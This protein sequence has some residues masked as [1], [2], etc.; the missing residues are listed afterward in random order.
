MM[1]ETEAGRRWLVAGF[2]AL[3]HRNFRL[4][5]VG[6][7]LSLVGTWMQS[8]ALGWLVFQ[9]SGSPFA[10]GA[11]AACGYLPI[12]CLAPAAGAVA[13]RVPKRQL[14]LVT[15]TLAMLLALVLAVLVA[16]DRVTTSLVAVFAACL[17]TVSAFDIPTRQAFIVEMVGASDLPNAIALNSSIFNGARL[18]GPAVAGILVGEVGLAPCFFINAATYLAVLWALA[19]MQLPRAARPAAADAPRPRLGEGLRYVWQHPGLR[20]L[21]L[22]MGVVGS[23]GLQYTVLM[24]AFARVV[25]VTD[26]RGFG[27]LVTAQGL[28]AVCRA[29]WLASRRH[30]RV[31]RRRHLLMGLAVFAAAVGGLGLTRE[32]GVAL[33]LQ[34]LAGYGMIGYTATTNTSIQLLVD[35][36]FRGRVMGLHAVMFLGTAPLGSL[37]LGAVA[38][39]F[40]VPTAFLFSGTVSALAAGWL[41][42]RLRRLAREGAPGPAKSAA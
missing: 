2:P 29:L 16:T 6:Q 39:S 4:F 34:A 15:Q 22:L 35:D 14:I 13:D 36:R 8:V 38:R 42:L 19:R 11:V 7:G 12:F 41:A 1:P 5:V 30:T 31:E 40:G 26:A 27:W 25:L 21:L 20:T 28:G 23:L 24:P 9:L 18:V 33:A 17:G 37:V 3:R 10:L 32:F